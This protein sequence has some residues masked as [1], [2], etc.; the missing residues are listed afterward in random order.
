MVHLCYND[1]SESYV[2][3][4][5]NM[6][7]TPDKSINEKFI[8]FKFE[9]F[10][11]MKEYK[12]E[13]K[14]QN[15]SLYDVL[16]D[17]KREALTDMECH[18]RYEDD[19]MAVGNSIYFKSKIYFFDANGG[20]ISSQSIVEKID[21]DYKNEKTLN[22]KV[23]KTDFT[24]FSRRWAFYALLGLP[25][26]SNPI[27]STDLPK[28]LI[29]M[30]YKAIY[31]HISKIVHEE[32]YKKAYEDIKHDAECPFSDVAEDRL[33]EAMLKN[34][35]EPTQLPKCKSDGKDGGVPKGFK[36]FNR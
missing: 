14:K 2:K 26:N 31:E 6:P 22:A 12:E 36:G 4:V 21:V 29:T 17:A 28:E 1:N 18:L 16:E 15:K 20:E 25:K 19:V 27:K 33:T 5:K 32:E 11:L 23:N 7:K 10:K 30:S 24:E 8:A 3:G 9:F 35:H 13:N 34:C